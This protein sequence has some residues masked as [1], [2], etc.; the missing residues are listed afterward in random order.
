MDSCQTIEP[1]QSVKCTST[2][3]TT[4][5]MQSTAATVCNKESLKEPHNGRHSNIITERQLLCEGVENNSEEYRWTEELMKD[6]DKELDDWDD[7]ITSIHNINNNKLKDVELHQDS[8]SA[9]ASSGGINSDAVVTTSERDQEKVVVMGVT[10]SRAEFIC[11][12]APVT[13]LTYS[14]KKNEK[15]QPSLF[16]SPKMHVPS[17][18]KQAM[19]MMSGGSASEV[20]VVKETPP[21]RVR[22]CQTEQD[23]LQKKAEQQQC[24]HTHSK[25]KQTPSHNRVNSASLS[26]NH[27]PGTLQSGPVGNLSAT[28]SD[29]YK[30]PT[31]ALSF[32][33]PS[34]SEWMKMKRLSS[35]STC[36]TPNDSSCSLVF[37]SGGKVTPPL[38]NCGKRTKRRTVSNPGPNEGKS[39]YACPNGKASDKNRGCGFFKW[40]AKLNSTPQQFLDSRSRSNT[41]YCS[42][43]ES[44]YV[45]SE[46]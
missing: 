11:H 5:P 3:E 32:R 7:S 17:S 38:C 18:E 29:G 46:R 42:S 14:T 24:L 45:E 25:C 40:E 30:T 43:L 22:T 23:Q 37:L 28:A 10:P 39:F 33:T 20:F 27:T 13:S 16:P 6:L 31:C 41:C 36:T 1:N 35:S 12:I 26:V 8:N 21:L 15:P 9:H 4:L 19:V 2:S 44:E 34:S